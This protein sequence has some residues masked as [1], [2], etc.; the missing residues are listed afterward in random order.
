MDINHLL[1]SPEGK[2]L[3]FK[4][5]F[6]SPQKVTRAVVAFANTAGGTIIIGVEDKSKHVCG[7]A[8]PYALEEKLASSINDSI[9][10][11]VLPEIE[12]VPWRNL[13]L[14]VIHVFPSSVRP[15]YIKKDGAD[16][17]TYIRVG[18][19][20]RLADQLMQAEL[21]RV[22]IEDSFDK[23]PIPALN[24]E[25]IDF[26]VASDL[27]AEFKKLTQADLESLDLVTNY[28]GK[29]APTAGGM[30]LFGKE[31]LKYFPEA[32]IQAGRFMGTTKTK[33]LD[34]QEIKEYPILAID[35]V[36]KFIKKHAMHGVE[37]PGSSQSG[38]LTTSMITSQTTSLMSSTRNKSTWN[39]PL[40]AIREAIINAVVHADYS[41]QGAP[42]RLSIFDDR[43]EIE[44]PGLLLFGLTVDEIKRGV[45]K[46]RNR[47]IGQVFY[48]LGLIER[49]GSGI[50]RIMASCQEAGFAEP[51]FEEVATHFRVTLFTQPIENPRLNETDQAIIEVLKSGGLGGL[52]TKEI[53]ERIGKSP[54]I[55]RARLVTLIE[56]GMVIELGS[57]LNDPQRK[58]FYKG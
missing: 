38:S 10:P 33:I 42:I 24:S 27:F 15:H 21:R 7:V 4:Q 40:T 17:G 49:W 57:G 39:L 46:L 13:Y 6:S 35:E 11:Q 52:S 3:E 51:V 36:M 23:Q 16:K 55:T 50:G 56:R 18:S 8:D 31:R 25:A 32:W 48:R 1:R 41:Q 43:I 54:R 53:S 9:M 28:Q 12:I 19:T 34:T 45:S 14:V 26:R 47:V 2:T 29:K 58:Y 5:D 30:I 44:N 37:I 22:K 20:N